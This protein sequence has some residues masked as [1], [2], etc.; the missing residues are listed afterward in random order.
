M[1][2]RLLDTPSS[3]LAREAKVGLVRRVQVTRPVVEV[4]QVPTRCSTVRAD[5]LG[6]RPHSRCSRTARARL[7]P[8]RSRPIG[9]IPLTPT[10]ISRARDSRVQSIRAQSAQLVPERLTA[11]RAHLPIHVPQTRVVRAAPAALPT[12]EAAE[13]VVLEARRA[14]ESV[15]ATATSQ[16]DSVAAVVAAARTEARLQQ[17]SISLSR[18]AL[19][20]P[21]VARVHQVLE[22]ARPVAARLAMTGQLVVVAAGARVTVVPALL[23]PSVATVAI[24]AMSRI[25]S[26]L[27]TVRMLASAVEVVQQVVQQARRPH[28]W[29]LAA[30]EAFT[31]AAAAAFLV[32]ELAAPRSLRDKARLG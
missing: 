3:W 8:W 11:R 27:A 21:L 15:V 28:R 17:G 25:G 10:L 12:Q 1:I 29:V 23:H 26:K 5:S 18:L 7:A 31:A 32:R 30:L 4:A 2:G 6:L 14:L 24:S 19:Q 13:V 16:L 20:Q 22:V 9:L